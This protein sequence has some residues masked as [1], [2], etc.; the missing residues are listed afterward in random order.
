MTK[1]ILALEFK[2]CKSD[3][4]M[5]YFINKETRELVLVIIYVN[6][7]CFISSKDFPLLLELKSKFIMKLECCN[8]Q[9]WRW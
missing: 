2:Q 6:N 4:N 1:L 9:N 3:A 8:Y 7:I 5:Y